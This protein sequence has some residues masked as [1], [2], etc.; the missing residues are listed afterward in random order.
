MLKFAGVF[1]ASSIACFCAHAETFEPP[2]F[3]WGDAWTY[4]E[5]ST[6]MGVS[7]TPVLTE[8]SVMYTVSDQ[9]FLTGLRQPNKNAAWL[10]DKV[11][12]RST[13]LPFVP[14]Q[15]LNLDEAFCKD[16]IEVGHK[17]ESKVRRSTQLTRFE[18]LESIV[19][20]AGT[21]KA[22]HFVRIESFSGEGEGLLSITQARTDL[23]FVAKIRAFARVSMR[24]SD[25]NGKVIDAFDFDL[26]AVDLQLP[27]KGRDY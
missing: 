7:R 21:F 25:R 5:S 23:W 13:C 1:L 16:D 27:K 14:A 9:N 17:I 11:L 2:K 4:L 20:K 18:G 6:R 19:T 3:N 10:I 22:A 26:T 12:A 15:F 24:A 8:Y